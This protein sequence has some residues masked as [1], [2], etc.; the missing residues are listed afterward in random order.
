MSTTLPPPLAKLIEDKA[1]ADL[2]RLDLL[3]SVKAAAEASS[4]V[5][6]AELLHVSQPYVSNRIKQAKLVEDPQ[7]YE[8]CQRFAAHQLDRAEL[9]S[10]LSRWDY[11]DVPVTSDLADDLR[12][13]TPGS[14]DEVEAAYRDKLID[15]DLYDD[16]LNGH[17]EWLT[18]QGH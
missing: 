9:I 3:R 18:S 10:V 12:F 6:V 17:D 14:F 16:I 2:S 13:D 7:P 8:M 15:A 5:E 1:R 4:Q 11:V